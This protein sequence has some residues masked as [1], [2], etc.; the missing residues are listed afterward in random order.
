MSDIVMSLA[1]T[2]LPAPQEYSMTLTSVVGNKKGLDGSVTFYKK[3]GVTALRTVQITWKALNTTERY[4]L[5]SLFQAY[6][7]GSTKQISFT[8][9][10]SETYS[11]VIDPN[12]ATVPFNG[13]PMD[14]TSGSGVDMLWDMTVVLREFSYFNIPGD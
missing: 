4:D 3:S 10:S 14:W 1:G 5:E 7:T 8:D 6:M 2:P 12:V 11:V 9:L 13:E